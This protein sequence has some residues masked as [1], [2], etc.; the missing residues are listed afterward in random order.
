M[1]LDVG[2]PPDVMDPRPVGCQGKLD[3]LFVVSREE[4]MDEA[5][6]A[7]VTAFPDLYENLAGLYVGFD[8]HVMVVDADDGWGI[9]QC[10][11]K[12]PKAEFGCADYPCDYT[13]AV[14]DTILGAGTVFN[15]GWTTPNTPCPL[16]SGRR[17]MI[18]KDQP[19]PAE[20]FACLARVGSAGE[21]RL[22]AAAVAALS[23]ELRG[24]GGCNEDFLRDDALLV[25]IFLGRQDE[26]T[27]SPGDPAE[28][29][30]AILSA[31]DGDAKSVVILDIGSLSC[32]PNDRI[33]LLAQ[34]HFPYHHIASWS[35]LD[36]Y[37]PFDTLV[38][39]VEEACPATSPG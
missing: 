7:L 13:P 12:C 4:T 8:P 38:E 26:P 15:A 25:L 3:L 6:N 1:V 35:F 2:A 30:E 23:P 20:T 29:A 14:C 27:D 37:S 32:Q 34:E 33:C 24:P 31:K 10:K 5:Q 17:F 28:W 16:T 19:D 36:Y 22:G 21:N 18:G 11:A 39:L 9:P